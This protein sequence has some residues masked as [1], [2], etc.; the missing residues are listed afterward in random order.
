MKKYI[1]FFA[2]I[3]CVFAAN[4]QQKGFNKH[5]ADSLKADEY[6]MK[7]YVM[8]FLK[9]GP[10]RNQ[11]SATAASLQKAHMDNIGRM[12][13]EGKLVVA[14]PFLDNGDIRGIYIFD[15]K[16]IEEAKKLTETDPAVQAG[17]LTMELHLWYCSAALM[18]VNPIHETLS[19]KN[20]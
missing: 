5:L 17:R 11:D 12:A 18:M 9:K 1:L 4:A 13:K 3:L 8:A 7:P 15:V 6:G 14:G 10:N 19:Q 20:H 16:T 2:I